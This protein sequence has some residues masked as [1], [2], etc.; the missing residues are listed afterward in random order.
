VFSHKDLNPMNLLWDG[1]R[2][3]LLDWDSAGPAHP[4][5]DLATLANFMNL[6]DGDALGL[7]A[8]Q[9]RTAIDDRERD[10][11]TER[12]S[13]P[14][15]RGTRSRRQPPHRLQQPDGEIL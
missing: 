14:V 5:M 3:W 11:S 8:A 7:L 4:Y 15:P 12:R 1:Q 9:E 13:S 10:P 2:V 6:A